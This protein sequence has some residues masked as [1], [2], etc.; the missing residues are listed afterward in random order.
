MTTRTETVP[1][2]HAVRR[3]RLRQQISLRELA[4]RLGVSPATLSAIETGR[5]SL[6]VQRLQRLA[7]LLEVPVTTLV[8]G[9]GSAPATGAGRRPDAPSRPPASS[10][11]DRHW[12]SF[13]ELPLDRVL[14]GAVRAFLA[15]GY[16][17][18]NMRSIARE[19]GMSV[20]G[21]YH[22]HPSKQDLLVRILDAT[23]TDL[24]WRLEQARD[25]GESPVER[26]S[27]L[28]EA[29]ALFHARRSEVAFIGASEMRSLLDDNYR[30]IAELR[31]RVQQLLDD[32][33]AAVVDSQGLQLAYPADAGKAI[34]TMCTGLAQWFHRD[35]P[36]SPEQIAVEYADF[37][38]RLLGS[39]PPARPGAQ[40]TSSRPRTGRS[41]RRPPR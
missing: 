28:V 17:G 23:M 16:H 40:V 38:V 35:G 24:L 13:D 29:L 8:G 5:T 1:A 14:E 19:A 4:R 34:A 6:S 3:E 26:L 41:G 7:E 10:S 33:I 25:E 21:V 18:A 12:R 20:P 11:A 37:A 15:T 27:L 30:R 31:N 39:T 22:H 36:T 2:G 32:G 9:D